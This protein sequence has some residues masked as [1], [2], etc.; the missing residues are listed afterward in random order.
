MVSK[1]VQKLENLCMSKGASLHYY[2]FVYRELS[3]R[4]VKNCNK[5]LVQNSDIRGPIISN[6]PNIC[7]NLSNHLY[8]PVQEENEMAEEEEE[9][10]QPVETIN[11]GNYKESR[12][13]SSSSQSSSGKDLS[14]TSENMTTDIDRLYKL[15]HELK[16]EDLNNYR[17]VPDIKR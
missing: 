9:H 15:V 2:D 1:N 5:I 7:E 16:E 3:L 14:S 12:R 4:K 13:T 8:I 11:L 17:L 10:D 6:N